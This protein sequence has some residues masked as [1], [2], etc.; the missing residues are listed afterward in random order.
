[1]V[2]LLLRQHPFGTAVN[3]DI[4]YLRLAETSDGIHF[5]DDGPLQGLNDPTDVT[6]NGTRWLA[7]AGTILKLEGSPYV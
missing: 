3:N 7:T 2:V 6:A 5:K 1:L 4:T